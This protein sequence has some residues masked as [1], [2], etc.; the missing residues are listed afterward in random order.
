ML[1]A[2]VLGVTVLRAYRLTEPPGGYHSYNEG[3]YLSLAEEYAERGPIS[4][5]IRPAD[6]NN[7]PLFPVLAAFALK[8]LPGIA[9]PR[10]AS[11]LAGA[12]AV[13]LVYAL[14]RRLY[15]ARVGL[16]AAA[17]FA[18]MPGAVLIGRN[19]Q[20]DML[21]VCL[22]LAFL[23]AFVRAVGTDDRRWGALAGAI[24]GLAVVTKLPALFALVVVALW[25]TAH[26]RSLRWMASRAPVW[27]MGAFV[28]VGA[29]WW[30]WRAASP[31]LLGAQA[32]LIALAGGRGTGSLGT[33][34]GGEAAALAGLP[35]L[36]LAAVGAAI[37]ARRR[38]PADLLVLAG[39]AVETASY[40]VFHY[41]TYYL[42]TLTPYLALAVG[43]GVLA[44]GVRS[45]RGSAATSLAIALVMSLFA[46]VT[47]SAKKWG[48]WDPTDL[49]P[50]VARL[51]RASREVAVGETVWAHSFGP[52][53]ERYS[54][55]V[56]VARV[57]SGAPG[58]AAGELLFT[59]RGVAGED[60]ELAG[61][62]Y[63]DRCRP[64]ASGLAI[65]ADPGQVNLL[66][67]GP[68]RAERVGSPLMMGVDERRV[69]HPV[70]A[71]F[72]PGE[73]DPH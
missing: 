44:L 64:V 32:D 42:L 18:F 49:A 6:A 54:D 38:Q 47:L 24:L 41:H 16:T 60:F 70:W 19:A 72:R 51:G 5:A 68:I 22:E 53:L 63:L 9:G 45:L 11:M 56:R 40:V 50:D 13:L 20:A 2:L 10:A 66:A 61:P 34:L 36:V 29:P 39:L 14:G 7:P 27:M 57:G 12:A 48:H 17:A 58:E 43:R 15:D 59:E 35:L 30:V 31:G 71:Y 28:A 8:L 4:S 69:E 62:A 23:A 26:L 3:F 73:E 1:L 33:L 46:G 67:P 37:A 52:A 21:L 25:R 55:G 65:D